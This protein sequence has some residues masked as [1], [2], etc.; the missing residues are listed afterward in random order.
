MVSS[1]YVRL[2]DFESS[3]PKIHVYVSPLCLTFLGNLI[4]AEEDQPWTFQETCQAFLSVIK[5]GPC[6]LV[7]D[8]IDELGV[9]MGQTSRQVCVKQSS[10]ESYLVMKA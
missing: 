6:V 9:T 3:L 8:G 10:V 4:D 1:C 7:L 5:L 2:P